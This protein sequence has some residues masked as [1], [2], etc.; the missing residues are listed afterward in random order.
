MLITILIL[1]T[2]ASNPAK[3][4][5]R[6]GMNSRETALLNEY[7]EERKE[8]YADYIVDIGK[9]T[10][11]GAE[12]QKKYYKYLVGI[13]GDII[14]NR[15]LGIV[16]GSIGFYYDKKSQEKGRLFLGLDIDTGRYSE[17][18][19]SEAALKLLKEFT[20]GII[21]TINACNTIFDEKE[22]IG[23]VI[24]FRWKSG[25]GEDQVNIWINEADVIRFEK[26]VLT[27]DELI[28]RSTI[29]DTSG[30]IIIFQ[31]LTGAPNRYS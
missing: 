25:K 26:K 23:M 7:S 15:K 17:N 13:A 22:I 19:Y 28:Q 1:A 31:L 10:T 4:E 29:T 8:K 18:D 21:E 2:C 3:K 20:A 30:K 9:Y 6:T 16:R 27:F 14:E 12:Y 24:G 11:N 5:S